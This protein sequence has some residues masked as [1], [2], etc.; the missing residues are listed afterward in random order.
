MNSLMCRQK[1]AAKMAKR[2]G[3][4]KKDCIRLIDAMVEEMVVSLK[5]GEGVHLPKLGKFEYYVRKES[6]RFDIETGEKI[7]VPPATRV[8]FIPCK[9]VKYGVMA[10]DW[11]PHISYKQKTESAWYKNILKEREQENQNNK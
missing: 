3:I 6:F 10:L 4:L 5:S 8:K 7:I 11:E 9:D 1:L 2:T